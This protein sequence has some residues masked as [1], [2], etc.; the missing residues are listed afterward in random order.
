MK[1]QK[2]KDLA[3]MYVG[4]D[5]SKEIFDICLMEESGKVIRRLQVKS[6]LKGFQTLLKSIPEGYAPLFAMETTGSL[7]GNLEKFLEK[8]D[9]TFVKANAFDVSRI[10]EAFSFRQ[11]NDVVD[12]WVLAQAARLNVLRHSN[13]TPEFTYLRDILERYFDLDVRNTAIKNQLHA[14]LTETFPEV[15]RVFS[16]IEGKACLGI[17]SKYQTPDQYLS[18]S[19][20]EIWQ[21][22]RQYN[23]NASPKKLEKLKDLAR[24]SV[25]WKKSDY[26]KK[27]IESRVREMIIIKEE[28]ALLKDMMNKYMETTFPREMKLLE[29]IPGFGL[30]TSSYLLSVI[31]DY[32]RF[33]MNRDGKGAKRVSSFVGFSVIEYSSG[34]RKRKFGINKRGNPKLRGILYFAAI[35]AIRLDPALRV[36]YELKR[37]KSNGRKALV[38]IGHLL[39]RRAYGVLKTGQLYNPAIPQ[40]G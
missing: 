4:I 26:T 21:V 35:N 39:L 37:D 19:I 38:A 28:I 23:G 5:I 31:G 33:D 9:Q 20:K 14:D 29:S 6:N 2:D 7:S 34:P 22:I 27:I 16:T 10:R 32:R 15:T 3:R 12:A 13:T 8:H 36:K 25:A 11:K 30:I 1:L 24:T 18:A 40:A 17:L